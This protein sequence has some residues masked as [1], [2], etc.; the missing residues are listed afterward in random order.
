V[1]GLKA[2]LNNM[3]NNLKT[4]ESELKSEKGTLS[5]VTTIMAGWAGLVTIGLVVIV[6]VVFRRMRS[7]RK[8]TSWS[9]TGSTISDPESARS[10]SDAS[11]VVDFNVPLPS[12]LHGENNR[13]YSKDVTDFPLGPSVEVPVDVH[14]FDTNA[15]LNERTLEALS[16]LFEDDDN[17]ADLPVVHDQPAKAAKGDKHLTSGRQNFRHATNFT[18]TPFKGLMFQDTKPGSSFL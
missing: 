1:L 8:T 5:M 9:S 7:N 6:A 16:G 15:E 13:G 3:Q 18:S 11:S 12:G 10:S 14:K 17:N 4:E 2:E